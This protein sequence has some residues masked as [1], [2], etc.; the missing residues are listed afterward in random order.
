MATT[1]STPR[2]SASGLTVYN[3][4]DPVVETTALDALDAVHT[5]SLKLLAMARV[6][7]GSGVIERIAV[8]SK[9]DV[10]SPL[11]LHFFTEETSQTA[12]AAFATTDAK[13]ATYI[14]TVDTGVWRDFDTSRVWATSNKR[15]PYV[16]AAGDT[17]IYLVLQVPAGYTP[18]Y[19][20]ADALTVLV[21]ARRDD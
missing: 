15:I 9:A 18:T 19:G 3:T 17:A 2:L 1:D 7:G 5:N 16:C 12:D 4:V 11:E 14:D 13:A 21:Q 10:A 6:A 8:I 20:A